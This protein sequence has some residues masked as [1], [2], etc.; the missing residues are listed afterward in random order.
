MSTNSEFQL[1]ERLNEHVSERQAKGTLIHAHLILR[2]ASVAA[3]KDA[4]P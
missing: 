3:Q 1:Q 2:F 4:G